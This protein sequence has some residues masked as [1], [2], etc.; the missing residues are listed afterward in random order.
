ML[1]WAND[2]WGKIEK[3]LEVTSKRTDTGIFPYTTEN[4]RFVDSRSP[5]AWTGG[6]WVGIMWKMY[7]VTKKEHYRQ[8]AEEME[9]NLDA[10]LHG[11]DGLHHDVGFM[12]LLSSVAS[13]QITGSEDSKRRGMIAANLLAGRYNIVGKF[14][15]AWNQDKIGWSIIDTMMNIPLLYWASRETNDPRFKFIAQSHADTTLQNFIRPDGSVNHIVSFD[16][17]T[18]EFIES[19]G[20]QGYGVGSSWTRGQSWA[21]YGF[22]LSYIHTKKQEYLDAAKR[23][24]HYF[25]AALSAAGSF[26]PDCDFRSPKE[27]VYKDTTAGVIAACGMIE[28]AKYVPE[29]EKDLYLNSAWSILKEIEEDYTDWS[30]DEDLIL[31]AGTQSYANGQNIPIVYGD[32]Y[33][34]EAVLKLRGD[35]IL[36][37]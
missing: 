14:I 3:K 7:N 30:D 22:A 8:I 36:F 32:Y 2:V 31:K 34:I 35:N 11:F 16:P 13:Y 20:G 27:P 17:H 15:R 24:A 33:F 37:W 12:W 9:V 4:G 1:N 6:F 29:G 5:Y 25:I 23:V 26:V 28:I 10:G 21:V 18:G 19:M